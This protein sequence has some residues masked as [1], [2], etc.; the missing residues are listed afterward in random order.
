[1]LR[2]T[3]AELEST[4]SINY[5]PL[6]TGER[7]HYDKFAKNK[8]KSGW[9]KS[10]S[11]KRIQNWPERLVLKGWLLIS[12]LTT[13]TFG[14]ILGIRCFDKTTRWLTALCSL[15]TIYVNTQII[16]I[17]AVAEKVGGVRPFS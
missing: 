15:R 13:L 16:Q 6:T 3:G 12:Y 1:M 14:P 11:L 9:N 7:R 4:F 5:V 17:G 10:N 2:I 8:E